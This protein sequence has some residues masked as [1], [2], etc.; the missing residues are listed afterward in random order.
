M[1]KPDPAGASARNCAAVIVTVYNKAPYVRA[2]I[3]SVLSQTLAPIEFVVVDDGSTDG[4]V[5][6]VEAAL[7]G[8]GARLLRPP[9]GGVSR[10]RTLGL[11]ACSTHPSYLLFLDGDDV[12]LPDALQTMCT[13]MDRHPGVAMCYSIPLLIDGHDNSLGVDTDQVRWA[14]T[15]CGRRRIAD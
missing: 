10:A 15:T 4:S 13:H 11:Q 5:E 6:I 1:S 3:D 9:N 14:A 2:C 8:S 12:L 7:S